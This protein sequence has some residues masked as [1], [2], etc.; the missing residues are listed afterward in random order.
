MNNSVTTIMIGA[1]VLAGTQAGCSSDDVK[2]PATSS[3]SASDADAEADADADADADTGDTGDETPSPIHPLYFTTMTH[4]EAGHDDDVSEF[5]FDNH[6][7]RLRNTME[8]ASAHSG[9]IT[10][11]S[12][13]PF[14]IGCETWG[15]NMMAEVLEAGHGVG[16]HCDRD[17]DAPDDMPYADFVAELIEKKAAVDALVGPENNTGCS[18]AGGG[19][20]GIDWV[21]GVADAGFGYINAIVSMHYLSMPMDDRPEGWSDTY[22]QA[23]VSHEPAPADLFDRIYLRRLADSEDFEH[24]PDGRLV[25]SAGGLGVLI[26]MAEG[27]ES[28][29]FTVAD[30]DAMVALIEEVDAG[31]DPTRVAK[32]D[33]HLSLEVMGDEATDVLTYFFAELERLAEA[34][35]IQWATQ[36][37]VVAAYTA[38]L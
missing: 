22:I 19:I 5:V 9:V 35:T 33:V 10:I 27:E 30:V 37:E 7:A 6:V 29:V 12:E 4:M 20:G 38:A 36:A 3:N 8:I 31:R 25:M 34:G 17:R 1:A 26:N 14:A 23:V 2:D 16:T 24:D 21:N 28:G 32:V 13:L 15:L 18:G 11:E